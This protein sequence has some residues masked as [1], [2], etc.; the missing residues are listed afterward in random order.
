MKKSPYSYVEWV[1]HAYEF[2][3][4][5]EVILQSEKENHISILVHPA[6]PRVILDRNQDLI[7]QIYLLPK[8]IQLYFFGLVWIGFCDLEVKSDWMVVEDILQGIFK[9]AKSKP[10]LHKK[11]MIW[12]DHALSERACVLVYLKKFINNNNIFIEIND[13]L[14]ILSKNLDELLI[15]DKWKENNHR[16]F[17]LCAKYCLEKLH[18]KNESNSEKIHKETE[19]FFRS[20][21]DI[22]TGISVEQSV[23]YYNFDVTLLELVTNFICRYGNK[24]ESEG[25]DLNYVKS[26]KDRHISALAF[27]DGQLPAS[28]DT[29]LGL[30][31]SVPSLSTSERL[32][33]WRSLERLGHYR[34]ASKNDHFHYHVLS[35]N[36]ESAHGHHSPLH[37]DLWVKGFGMVL[38]DSGGPYKYGDKL[39]YEWFRAAKA[40]NTVAFGSADKE[41]SYILIKNENN[42]LISSYSCGSS[43]LSR[44]IK[45]DNHQISLKD[46]I[47][48]NYQWISSF[49]FPLGVSITQV[50]ENNFS[51][52][53]EI[54]ILKF[55]LNLPSDVSIELLETYVTTGGGVKNLSPTILIRG[56]PNM[57]NNY[58]YSLIFS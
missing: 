56:K 21:I 12:D 7:E 57:D 4:S 37:L 6:H 29:P 8:S 51:L 18:Y 17:H 22:E 38:V 42:E 5:D 23:S 11:E 46:K 9:Y 32:S 3:D 27:P 15:S 36:A 13:H 16:V 50:D 40:H 45:S 53:N 58:E 44:E 48:S 54:G 28:G 10:R 2:R 55:Q 31:V 33:C 41:K 43:S 26:N 35:H 52:K 47:N 34:G 24:F 19:D 49:H 14:E 30:K 1:K 39:R 25:L 20:L